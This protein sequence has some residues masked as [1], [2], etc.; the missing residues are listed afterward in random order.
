VLE[1]K[2]E[3]I[4]LDAN[5]PTEEARSDGAQMLE[6]ERAEIFGTSR[7][8]RK[9]DDLVPDHVGE[10]HFELLTRNEHVKRRRH[11]DEQIRG[12]FDRDADVALNELWQQVRI[13]QDQSASPRSGDRRFVLAAPMTEISHVRVSTIDDAKS[14]VSSRPG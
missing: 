2:R 7:E 5:R 12:L 11:H 6:H 14:F 8:R 3:G 10:P 4:G 13:D 1:E 9:H